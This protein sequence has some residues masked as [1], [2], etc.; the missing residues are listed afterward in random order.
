MPWEQIPSHARLA[1]NLR[2]IIA[3]KEIANRLLRRWFADLGLEEVEV[4]VCVAVDNCDADVVVCVVGV[5]RLV[6]LAAAGGDDVGRVELG[7]HCVGLARV[8]H[9]EHLMVS[10]PR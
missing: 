7:V 5:G 3:V 10:V 8:D 2:L 1:V 9:E 6:N 4:V